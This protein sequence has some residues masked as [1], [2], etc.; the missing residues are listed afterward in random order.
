MS[1]GARPGAGRPKG[2]QN[3]E[4][5]AIRA[6]AQKRGP[7]VIRALWMIVKSSDNDNARVAAGREIL[8]RGYGMPKQILGHEGA[9]AGQP[10]EIKVTRTLVRPASAAGG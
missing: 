2:R 7:A 9:D 10:I 3:T 8:N 1:G 6:A 5:L 4:T